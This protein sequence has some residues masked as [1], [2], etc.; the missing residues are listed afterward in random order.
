LKDERDVF[1]VDLL[2]VAVDGDGAVVLVAVAVGA[3]DRPENI[4]APVLDEPDPFVLG[5]HVL[6]FEAVPAAAAVGDGTQAPGG[7]FGPDVGRDVQADL[8]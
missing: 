4:P 6:D 1:L 5:G 7:F 3:E 2:L 8:S